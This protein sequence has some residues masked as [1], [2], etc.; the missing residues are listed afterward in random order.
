MSS[1]LLRFDRFQRLMS[2]ARKL[3]GEGQE[4][5]HTDVFRFDAEAVAAGLAGLPEARDA[6]RDQRLA[7]WIAERYLV[8]K[9]KIEYFAQPLLSSEPT[10]VRR[11]TVSWVF[12]PLGF[13]VLP[14]FE[15]VLADA[16]EAARV[17]PYFGYGPLEGH[18][19]PDLVEALETGCSD[20]GPAPNRQAVLVRT[21]LD[22]AD[23]TET[24]YRILDADPFFHDPVV[25]AEGLAEF[26]RHVRRNPLTP[27]MEERFA[28]FFENPI[29]VGVRD[30]LRWLKGSRHPRMPW[31]RARGLLRGAFDRWGH[32][33]FVL[34]EITYYTYDTERTAVDLAGLFERNAEV[35]RA[36]A[37]DLEGR[38]PTSAQGPFRA[39]GA[40][41]LAFQLLDFH[42]DY[43]LYEV[44]PYAGFLSASSARA[45]G[46]LGL[47]L[48]LETAGLPVPGEG[49]L[50]LARLPRYHTGLAEW[51]KA[52]PARDRALLF[53]RLGGALA[54][55]RRRGGVRAPG[56]GVTR[57]ERIPRTFYTFQQR[58]D[59]PSPGGR[60]RRLMT[61]HDLQK[62]E[63]AHVWT[64]YP[65]L[66]EKLA[67]FFTLVYRHFEDT[68]YIADLRPRDSG[69][70]I[71]IY[72][73][74]GTVTEN[75]MVVEE[76]VGGREQ[77]RVVFVDNRD[78]FKDFR[79]E[80]DR[81]HPIGMAKYA[82][83]LVYPIIEPA[84][85][86]SVGVFVEELRKRE[87]G[88]VERGPKGLVD[89]LDQGLDIA[90]KVAKDSVEQTFVGTKAA[91]DDLIDDAHTGAK[92]AL[93]AVADREVPA[94]HGGRTEPP[95]E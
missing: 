30:T 24:A 95:R 10:R 74:W 13:S 82:L 41:R 79:G 71:F 43:R 29:T 90:R 63:N 47:A 19:A 28:D 51:F 39:H 88:E 37:A 25:D 58:A 40:M 92:R 91:V 55:Y 4:G 36:F 54:A 22:G 9:G 45:A 94:L 16:T 75:L 33:S 87:E 84:L 5:S 1:D 70:D 35:A 85:V 6:A 34:P 93:G 50:D 77:V 2:G 48:V 26:Q 14:T 76:E 57:F 8:K 66:S 38:L 53:D 49:N 21:F 62:P 89:V 61:I 78:Q 81:R 44:E 72:G 69:R 86:R 3:T 67:V 20:E 32:E 7:A 18:F 42:T 52:V 15:K 83:R 46:R 60:V 12:G 73:L 11:S 23:L 80:E 31:P 17:L 56:G 59:L 65:E 27:S 68:G 64:R